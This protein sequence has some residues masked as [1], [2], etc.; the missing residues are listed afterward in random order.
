MKMLLR[1]FNMV[2][3]PDQLKKKLQNSSKNSQQTSLSRLGEQP[4]FFCF[5]AG[6]ISKKA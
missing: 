6:N 3:Q 5:L 2:S 1:W 4:V